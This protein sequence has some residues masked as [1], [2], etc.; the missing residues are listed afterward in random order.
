MLHRQRGPR[1]SRRLR[2][3]REKQ[4]VGHIGAGGGAWEGELCGGVLSPA[5]DC[6]ELVGSVSAQPEP[7]PAP[8]ASSSASAA[9]RHARERLPRLLE[10]PGHH[11]R[12]LAAPLDDTTTPGV[13]LGK[14]SNIPYASS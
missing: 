10:R 14:G 6:T 8:H 4:R 1:A 5:P 2:W 13:Q 9:R 11:E 7:A 3:G 12:A